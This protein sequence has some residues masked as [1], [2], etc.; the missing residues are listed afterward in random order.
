M[1]KTIIAIALLTSSCSVVKASEVET[2]QTFNF[3]KGVTYKTRVITNKEMIYIDDEASKR[4]R[5]DENVRSK[6]TFDKWKDIIK[7][8]S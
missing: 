8:G 3:D 7:N 1:I 2:D 6:I 4:D 5:A